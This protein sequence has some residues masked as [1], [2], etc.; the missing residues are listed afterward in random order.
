MNEGEPDMAPAQARG[1]V[2]VRAD[3]YRGQRIG[4]YEVVSLLT[5]GGMAELFLA[6]TAGPGGFRKYVVIKRILPDIRSQEEFVKMF[7]DEARITAAFNHPNIGQV[8]DLGE[9]EDGLYLAM[10]FIA[11]Q[12]LNQ[13]T[14]SCVK[15]A[16]PLPVGF[17]CMVARDVCLALQYAHT[18]A[19]PTGKPFPIVHRDVA[20]KN[21]MV[22]YEG[23]TKLLDFG[24]AKARKKLGRTHVGMVKGTTGYMSPEQVRGD[25]IDGRSDL[26]SVGVMLHEMLLGRRLFSGRTEDEEMR[27]I[28]SSPVPVPKDVVPELPVELSNVVLRALARER[29]D[30]FAS[31]RELAKAI[32]Q[33]TGTLLFEREQASVF[34]R[35]LFAARLQATQSLL[36]AAGGRWDEAE[37]SAALKLISQD[38]GATFPDAHMPGS[39]PPP[40]PQASTGAA[41]TTEQQLQ[42][43]KLATE[44][45]A[46]ARPPN[47]SFTPSIVLA[48][49]LGLGALSYALY[50]YEA[51]TAEE[52]AAETKPDLH[53]PLGPVPMLRTF[54]EKGD[55]PLPP[56]PAVKAEPEPA[57]TAK[58]EPA[59]KTPPGKSGGKK[60]SSGKSGTLTLVTNPECTVFQGSKLLGQTPLFNASLPEG[61]HLLRL[62]AADGKTRLLSVPIHADKP[63]RFRLVLSELPLER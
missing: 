18:F 32:E 35:E 28:L 21:V 4:K 25:P 52:V 16:S 7:L 12:N 13:I 54:P 41:L 22:T 53:P 26:F 6:F 56:V 38:A 59:V 45:E 15:R 49:V 60:A 42:E 39:M 58:T 44:V 8:F 63:A 14:A 57:A 11:G 27:M 3:L 17:S 23:M 20:Q 19:D 10:E 33:A 47:R 30:R 37:V 36:Q 1:S 2:Q 29:A 40:G 24:I 50:R 51:Q 61:T 34:M 46:L 5:M 48:V 31:A 62:R 55:P 9:E 43:I